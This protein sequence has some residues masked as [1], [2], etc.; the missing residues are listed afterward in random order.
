MTLPLSNPS[1]IEFTLTLRIP[2]THPLAYRV[3]TLLRTVLDDTHKWGL[4]SRQRRALLRLDDR[5]LQDIGMSHATRVR[6]CAKP[7]WQA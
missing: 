3:A 2:A 5:M 1:E 7:F 6:E 4:R